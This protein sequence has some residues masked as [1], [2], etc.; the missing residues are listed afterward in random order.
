MSKKIVM[1]LAVAVVIA[2][3]SALS[4]QPVGAER[5]GL[6]LVTEGPTT[7]GSVLKE[8]AHE[9]D[10]HHKHH[11]GGMSRESF[12]AYRL[13]KLQEMA[14]YFGIPTEGKTAQQLKKE[15]IVAKE[16]NKEKWEAF[17]QEHEAKRLE[18]LRAIAKKHG[19]STEGKS[20]E[21]L[22]KELMESRSK[23]E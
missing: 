20:V 14:A 4:V 11:K 23:Q 13:K 16:T 5:L 21:Q 10:K 1:T 22:H 19:I 18:H 15:L 17:K 9:G 7:E 2:A 6:Q 8:P 12:E 3:A